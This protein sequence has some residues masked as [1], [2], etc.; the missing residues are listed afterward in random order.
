MKAHGEITP[1]GDKSISHRTF[2]FGALAHGTTRIQG[3]LE[4]RDVMS[5]AKAVQSLGIEVRKDNDTW[6]VTGGTLKEPQTVIDAG[7]SGTT[8][9]L[10]SGI[11]AGID[12]VTILTGD[13]SL[14]CRPMGRVI[15][16]L[17]KM[18]A[19]FLARSGRYLPMAIQ[20]GSLNGISYDME[21]ASAQVKSALLLAGLSASGTT[22]VR[23]PSKSRDHTERM[24]A[25]FGAEIAIDGTTICMSPGQKLQAREITVPSDPSSAAFPAVWAATTPGSSL[26]IRNVCINPTRIGFLHVLERM[27]ARITIENI[28]EAAGEPVGDI[29]VNGGVLHG[30]TIEGEEI[31]TLID[32]I[33]ILVVAACLAQGRTEIRDATELRVKETDRIAA[34][35]H[36]LTSLGAHV[37]END[38]GMTIEGPV[39][40]HSGSV[41]TFS[42]HRIA[43]CFHILAKAFD[44]DVHLDDPTCVDISYPG[45]FSSMETLV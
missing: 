2:L 6:V 42:D 33:P 4:S 37:A 43:M 23:E 31:P 21:I 16:P 44:I 26:L 29:R 35:V 13:S 22:T 12:G 3:V 25:Y 27:G 39:Q 19:R 41:R 32:E 24:L 11:C 40:L 7:N 18:G 30:T 15:T 8:A 9:R 34:M 1:P 45:F 14:V 20:G 38:D 28:R 5:T 36:G 10:L 17:E